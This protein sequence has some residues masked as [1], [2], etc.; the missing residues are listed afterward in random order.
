MFQFTGSAA[1]KNSKN[2][3][4][5]TWNIQTFNGK[6]EAIEQF[7]TNNNIEILGIT[8]TSH[9]NIERVNKSF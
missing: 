3:K 9:T 8:E 1:P 7:L 4:I 5:S 6:E 2:M